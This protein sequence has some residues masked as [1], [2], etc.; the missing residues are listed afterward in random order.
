MLAQSAVEDDGVFVFE[1]ADEFGHAV[2]VGV[3]WHVDA[4]GNVAADIVAVSH[5]DDS[6]AGR[7]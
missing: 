7:L 2:I 6:E 4:V 3:D 5:I 1:G